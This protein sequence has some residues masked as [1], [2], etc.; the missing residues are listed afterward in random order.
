MRRVALVVEYDGG[1]YAGWQR[2]AVAPSIQA[3]IEDAVGRLTQRAARVTGAGR[4]DAGVHALGQ[5]A[6]VDIDS[7]M[8]AH[9]I[10]AGLNALLPRDIVIRDAVEVPT[11]FHARRDA[12]LRV[13]RY[14][15]LARTRPSALL[16]GH[17]HY[18][19]GPLDIDA[20]RA[21]A[22]PLIGAHDF[23]AFRASGTETAT[24]DCVVR[25][26]R[27]DERGAAAVV[28]VAANRFLRQMVRRLV[29]TL[30]LVA[31]GTV[32]PERPAEIL[33]ARDPSRAGPPAPPHALYLV[34]V[35]YP[36]SVLMG[37]APGGPSEGAVL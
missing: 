25:A 36:A 13:Y 32:P 37:P 18:V 4:T 16:R 30:L 6:H 35:Y 7:T 5:V 27:I 23:A 31:R 28:T 14:V 2:Q 12:R 9:R 34:R 15:I 29:G 1:G 22:G 17:A 10:C 8:P 3:A 19:A 24:T 11:A 20:M 21:A 33:A 26:L